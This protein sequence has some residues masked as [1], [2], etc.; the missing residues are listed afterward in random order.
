MLVIRTMRNFVVKQ[1]ILQ[2]MSIM[3]SR[4][5]TTTKP[6]ENEA[7]LEARTVRSMMNEENEENKDNKE[8][9]EDN[10]DKENNVRK[11][12]GQEGD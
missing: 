3:S 8:N 4:R 12:S 10:E 1:G 11:K 7:N 6:K 9:H 5:I 2:N